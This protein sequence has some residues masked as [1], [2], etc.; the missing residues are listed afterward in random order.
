MAENDSGSSGGPS[1]H[2]GFFGRASII[3]GVPN[4]VL[5]VGGSA[6]LLIL[7][8][9]M[10]ASRNNPAP[11]AAQS[12]AAPGGMTGPGSGSSGA[13]FFMPNSTQTT[14]SSVNVSVNRQPGQADNTSYAFG[15]GEID[16]MKKNIGKQGITPENITKVQAAYDNLVKTKGVKVANQTHYHL[17]PDGTIDTSVNTSNLW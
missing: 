6:I 4:W 1:S 8:N 11:S 16:Y 7:L 2:G 5:I 12:S 17:N 3:K 15:L 9:Y 10:Q 13:V 14:P